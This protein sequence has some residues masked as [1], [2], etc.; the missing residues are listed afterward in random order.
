[1]KINRKLSQ[2]EGNGREVIKM[3]NSIL[4]L[5]L[6][7]LFISCEPSLLKRNTNA[8]KIEP[9]PTDTSCFQRVDVDDICSFVTNRILQQSQIENKNSERDFFL[10]MDDTTTYQ[11]V[12]RVFNK[13]DKDSLLKIFLST[14]SEKIGGKTYY[15]LFFESD[16][17]PYSSYDNI[18]NEGDKLLLLNKNFISNN[19]LKEE[20]ILFDFDNPKEE[21][22]VFENGAFGSK[23]SLK[24]QVNCKGHIFF[25][26]NLNLL[27]DVSH[28]HIPYIKEVVINKKFGIVYLKYFDGF[29]SKDFVLA[30]RGS[31]VK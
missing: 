9:E 24:K 1:M 17:F 23:V 21:R 30:D 18:R 19:S 2:Q 31:V 15:K 3:R 6:L 8:S 27:V 12:N 16:K 11:E 26:Y 28:S 20:Q 25:H 4:L 29:E 14:E 13:S 7:E 5:L 22:I 10:L